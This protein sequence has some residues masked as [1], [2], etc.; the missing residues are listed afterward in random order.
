[1]QASRTENLYVR[2]FWAGTTSVLTIQLY[3]MFLKLNQPSAALSQNI[4]S[5]GPKTTWLL[6]SS[7]SINAPFQPG[8]IELLNKSST[9]VLSLVIVK[10]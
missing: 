6:S 10:A 8:S 1:M 2:T 4:P 3:D 9:S 7:L 5:P